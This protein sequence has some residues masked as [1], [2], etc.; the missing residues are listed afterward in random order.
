MLRLASIDPE[1]LDGER[2]GYLRWGTRSSTA[3]TADGVCLLHYLRAAERR[4][5]RYHA[6]RG[7]EVDEQ[8]PSPCPLPEGEGFFGPRA[9][10]LARATRALALRA[11]DRRLVFRRCRFGRGLCRAGCDLKIEILERHVLGG[12]LVA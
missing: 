1:A 4:G 10:E 9:N 12:H 8:F 6:E 7:N 5:H 3:V 2:D 11:G